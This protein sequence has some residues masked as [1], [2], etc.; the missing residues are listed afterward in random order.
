M[1]K[2]LNELTVAGTAPACFLLSGTGFP[3]NQ[4]TLQFT[5]QKYQIFYLNIEVNIFNC[6]KTQKDFLLGWIAGYSLFS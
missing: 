5:E 6:F 2:T 4:K 3:F 1:L